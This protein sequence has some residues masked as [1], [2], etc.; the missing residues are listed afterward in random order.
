M[1]ITSQCV[2]AQEMA[3]FHPDTFFAPDKEELA[4]IVPGGHVKICV[5]PP[6]ERFWTKVYKVKG[7]YIWAKVNNNLMLLDWPLGKKIRFHRN[8]VYT[9]ESGEN[10]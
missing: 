4:R 3:C 2:D 8:H 9:I 7:N 6:G 10:M 1:N 5:N